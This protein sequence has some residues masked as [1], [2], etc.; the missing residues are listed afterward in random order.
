M[1][2]ETRQKSD[3]YLKK[4]F[5]P[6]TSGTVINIGIYVFLEPSNLWILLLIYCMTF[7]PQAIDSYSYTKIELAKIDADRQVNRDLVHQ[8]K[9]K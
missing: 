6:L 9:L 5:I 1:E 7:I 3:N 8:N 2:K 4:L